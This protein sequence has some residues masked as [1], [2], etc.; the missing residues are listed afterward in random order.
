MANRD[1][2]QCGVLGEYVARPVGV[3]PTDDLVGTLYFGGSFQTEMLLIEDETPGA[4]VDVRERREY[5]LAGNIYLS[6]R[7]ICDSTQNTFDYWWT[8]L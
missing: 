7:V 8:I 1:S 5:L 6:R 4:S 2:A 3:P